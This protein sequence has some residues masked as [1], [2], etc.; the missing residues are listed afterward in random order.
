MCIC[1][2]NIIGVHYLVVIFLTVFTSQV[3]WYK[4]N[5]RNCNACLI[6]EIYQSKNCHYRMYKIIHGATFQYINVAIHSTVALIH[7]DLLLCVL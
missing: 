3:G 1:V 5:E 6:K 4:H 2:I 7:T